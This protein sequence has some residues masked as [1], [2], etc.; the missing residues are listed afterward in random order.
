[1]VLRPMPSFC[2]ASMRRP[3]VCSSAARI[4]HDSTR[5]KDLSFDEPASRRPTWLK[6]DVLQHVVTGE[7]RAEV[8]FVARYRIGGGR[9]VRMREHSR[10]VRENG[11][12]LYVD[13]DVA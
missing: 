13:G 3:C 2:A 11:A 10:F 6:L 12:W 1:M 5:P 7:D 4:R 9:V 8:E